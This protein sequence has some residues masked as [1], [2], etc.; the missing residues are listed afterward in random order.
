MNPALYFMAVLINAR[1]ASCAQV[2]E[3]TFHLN[4]LE[5]IF[6]LRLNPEVY[7]RVKQ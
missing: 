7:G 3:G 5:L 1:S 6:S 2:A 4:Q